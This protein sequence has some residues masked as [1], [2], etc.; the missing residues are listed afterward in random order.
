MCG[1]LQQSCTPGTNVENGAPT[2]RPGP[3][4]DR[5]PCE[6]ACRMRAPC[7]LEQRGR[8]TGEPCPPAAS[9]PL[10]RRA[11]LR[12]HGPDR[13]GRPRASPAAPEAAS[14]SDGL[15]SRR[16]SKGSVRRRNPQAQGGGRGAAA[17]RRFPGAAVASRRRVRPW[18]PFGDV[19]EPIAAVAGR[20]R[21]PRPSRPPSRAARILRPSP[22]C[23]PSPLPSFSPRSPGGERGASLRPDRPAGAPRLSPCPTSAGTSLA[24]GLPPPFPPVGAGVP[25]AESARLSLVPGR[26]L[27]EGRGASLLAADGLGRLRPPSSQP[28]CPIIPPVVPWPAPLLLGRAR[29]EFGPGCRRCRVAAAG[30]ARDDLARPLAPVC[31]RGGPLGSSCAALDQGWG[32][33][34]RRGSRGLVL[35]GQAAV[36][37]VILSS[38]PARK[39]A[40]LFVTQSDEV[41]RLLPLYSL[42]PFLPSPPLSSPLS[43]FFWSVRTM[44]SRLLLTRPGRWPSSRRLRVRSRV[45]CA[46]QVPRR[47][48]AGAGV[49]GAPARGEGRRRGRMRPPAPGGSAHQMHRVYARRAPG[50]RFARR[51]STGQ[52]GSPRVNQ[53]TDGFS[54]VDETG[55]SGY[56]SLAR[57]RPKTKLVP[58]PR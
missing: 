43:L 45:L 2:R 51:C 52:D 21:P 41:H 46:L 20:R 36:L 53:A 34:R 7:T 31:P 23:S 54:L 49:G 40:I 1:S 14:P 58:R 29:R 55:G 12:R 37:R 8:R 27:G 25:R 19:V 28:P 4:L 17:R 10:R 15:A 11:L 26:G 13:T 9:I 39:H 24:P 32:P 3:Q 42:S 56:M 5:S 18:P 6:P 44:D 35:P 16:L 57:Y 22:C 48:P 47:R 38:G 30:G 33:G 50:L